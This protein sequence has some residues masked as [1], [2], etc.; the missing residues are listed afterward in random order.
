MASVVRG[1]ETDLGLPPDSYIYRIISTAAR[2][3]PLTYSQVDQLA[4]ISSDDSLRFLDPMTPEKNMI[5]KV[6]QKVTCLER[7]NDAASNVIATAGRDGLIRFWDKRSR[8]KVLEIESPHKLISALVCDAQNN[9]IAAGIENPDDGNGVS[10]VYIWDQRNPSAPTR[11]YID[12]H[13]DTITSL[14][15]HP[16]HP[17]LLLSASTD[18]LINIF[19]TAQADEEDA[20]Y[21]VINHG[22]AIAHAGFMF[23][24]TDIYALGTDETLSFYALQSQKEDEEEPAP[25]AFGDVREALGC[26]YLVKMH[27]VGGT[28][29][30]AAGK[31]SESNLS[32]IPIS[33]NSSKPLDYT[34]D[35]SK[36]I[37]LP[38]GH[39]EEVVRDMFTDVSTRTTYT[40]GEDGFVR[41]WKVTGDEAMSIDDAAEP[42]KKKKDKDRKEKRKEKKDKKSGE[43]EKARYKPY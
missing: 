10:P 36:S 26:E 5:K 11:S 24:G 23:P 2:Q 19:D 32:L 18:G 25:K 35:L 20:L 37:Q 30:V 7:A 9:F 42:A 27:W 8:E 40:C 41:T 13:T 38:G 21:Q 14:Q 3:D 15:L 43:K 31:H 12:S 4:I 1:F 28:P 29:Y 34:F 16:S 6:N 33:K 39:G 17:S 22:S